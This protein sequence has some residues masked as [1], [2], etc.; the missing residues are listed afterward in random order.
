M[1]VKSIVGIFLHEDQI[2]FLIHQLVELT[3]QNN[4]IINK[5]QL[6]V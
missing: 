1:T 5:I 6:G 2:A 3:N 4:V